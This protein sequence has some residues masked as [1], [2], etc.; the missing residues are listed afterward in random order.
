MIDAAL[1]LP[2]VGLQLGFAGAARANAAAQLRHG[3]ALAGQPRQHVLKLRQLHLQLAF[4]GAGM[5]RKDIQNQLRPV[6]HAARQCGLEIAQLC[7]REI[8][9]EEHQ[10][11]LGGSGHP[12][13]LLHLAGADQS[14]RIRT[15][16]TLQ[17]LGSHLAAGARHQLAKFRQRF[18]SVQARARCGRS[19]SSEVLQAAAVCIR[20]MSLVRA[21]LRAART[22]DAGTVAAGADR[23]GPLPPEPHAPAAIT[24]FAPVR[25]LHCQS[26]PLP[27][28]YRCSA[29]QTQ[30]DG[31]LLESGQ[32]RLPAQS[33]DARVCIT[34]TV[35]HHC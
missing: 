14:G 30:T 27:A 29:S 20:R 15:R 19:C 11:G 35:A 21:H 7:G 12:G 32:C 31:M 26:R 9:V 1:N 23:L 10:I 16:P 24:P 33:G 25:S 18:L 6:Q 28:C 4:A 8:V 2:P 34:L 22:R 13:N 3:L 5:A 17:Q